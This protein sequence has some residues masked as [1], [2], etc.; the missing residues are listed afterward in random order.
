MATPLSRPVRRSVVTARGQTLIV[1]LTS[2]GI[3]LR[4]Y[5]RRR[6]F[7]LPYG[8]GF[9]QAVKLEVEA[10]RRAKAAAKAARRKTSS[11]S[12]PR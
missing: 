8:V 1:T 6:G 5:R 12:R 4:E 2:T 9:Q 10:D 7:L 11:S 3:E